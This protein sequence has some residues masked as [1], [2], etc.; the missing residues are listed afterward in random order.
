M[1][2]GGQLHTLATLPRGETTLCIVGWVGLT[3]RMVIMGEQ[4]NLLLL[5]GIKPRLLSCSARSPVA[6][7]TELSVIHKMEILS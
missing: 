2:V 1:E 7:L 6:V 5:Q 4:K 3:A